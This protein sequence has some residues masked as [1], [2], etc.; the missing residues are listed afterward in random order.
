MP[1]YL[2]AAARFI[3]KWEGKLNHAYLDTIASP[4]V[5]TIGYGWTGKIK[6]G[7]RWR[8]IRAGDY[9]SDK[10]ALYYLERGVRD[11]ARK[12]NKLIKVPVSRRQR[13]ACI[14]LAYNIGLGAF[15]SSTLLRKLNNRNYVG[16]ANEFPKWSYA[17]GVRVQGLLNRR[18]EERWMFVH[19]VKGKKLKGA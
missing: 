18:R 4:A 5:W 6:R 19:Y 3:G 11:F 2:K 16:A 8:S 10:E 7:G 13:M 15:A 12:V 17:G 14:S 9:M 1:A